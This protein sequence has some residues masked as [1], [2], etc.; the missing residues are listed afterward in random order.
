MERKRESTKCVLIVN[1]VSLLSKESKNERKTRRKKNKKNRKTTEKLK[2]R[3]IEFCVRK[4]ES[5]RERES[6]NTQINATQRTAAK[7]DPPE[8]F[9][10][11][12]STL[13][14]A[15]CRYCSLRCTTK[16]QPGPRCP[17]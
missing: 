17:R 12:V 1:V 2:R 6:R 13:N 3:N 8:P 9:S 16:L 11:E 15:V 7:S 14:Q 10:G 5:A 4:R